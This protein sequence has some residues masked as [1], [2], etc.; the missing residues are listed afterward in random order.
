ME[1]NW[2]ERNLKAGFPP[3]HAYPITLDWVHMDDNCRPIRLTAK[4]EESDKAEFYRK[5]L[6]VYCANVG[7]V[8][9]R[10]MR[11]QRLLMTCYE[12]F[13]PHHI[14]TLSDEECVIRYD[15]NTERFR[16]EF[17]KDSYAPGD[18]PFPDAQIASMV[19]HYLQHLQAKGIIFS[20]KREMYVG[21]EE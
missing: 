8:F 5:T 19:V 13:C 15:F 2:E 21:K 7:D 1:I 10:Q 4:D 11:L 9:G 12:R 18:I 6:N 14:P 17:I 20:S 3:L 16:Y